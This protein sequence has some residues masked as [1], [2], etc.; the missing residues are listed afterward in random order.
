MDIC[1]LM[2]R[3]KWGFGGHDRDVKPGYRNF[4]HTH[5]RVHIH[6]THLEPN[7]LTPITSL[8]RHGSVDRDDGR[9]A[10]VFQERTSSA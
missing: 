4:T 6:L 1:T 10:V 2:R 9:S 3:A 8:L 5:T 7:T